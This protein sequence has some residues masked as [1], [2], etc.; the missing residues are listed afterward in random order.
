[1]Q[2]RCSVQHNRMFFDNILQNIPYSR[3]QLLNHFLG[4]L[5]VV[6]S[7]VGNKLFHNERF[8]QLNGH[9]FR[10]TTLINLKFRSYNDNGTSGIV[11]SFT[12]KVL[13]ETSGFTFQHIRKGFQ[14]S[15]SRTCYRTSA[16]TVVDQGINSFL[17]H[18]F[19]VTNDN[20]RCT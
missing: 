14:G 8:E 4:V 10:K 11:N 13:T 15:V 2:C 18:T 12:E 3:L 5:N 1:M 19:L 9:L 7:S 6:R 17:K 20:I 16:T